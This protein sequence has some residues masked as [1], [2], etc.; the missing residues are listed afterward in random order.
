MLSLFLKQ[1]KT[2]IIKELGSL[3]GTDR[4]TKGYGSTGVSAVEMN[5]NTEE[6]KMTRNDAVKNETPLFKSRQIISARQI[7]KLAKADN[8][9]YLAIVRRTNMD[10]RKRMCSKR[11]S[12]RVAQFAAAHGM[13]EGTKRSIN[14]RVGP[15]K[16]IISVAER[17]QEVLESVPCKSPGKTGRNYP[18]VP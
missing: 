17:E 13:T 2:P 12:A 9:I 7:Q 3:E 10:P 16:D 14:K 15:K 4:G 5:E 6:P 1:L 18:G 11:S 8:P